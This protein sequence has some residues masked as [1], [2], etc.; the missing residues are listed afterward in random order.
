MND[1][2]KQTIEDVNNM[3]REYPVGSSSKVTL[4]RADSFLNELL[5]I[6]QKI[7]W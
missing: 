6:K 3:M 2:L 4:V 7:N 1:I 5:G